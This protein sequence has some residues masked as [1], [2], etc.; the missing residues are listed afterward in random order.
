MHI[1]LVEDDP[2]LQLTTTA[3]V[4]RIFRHAEVE[5]VAS[6]AAAIG[7]L[8]SSAAPHLVLSDFDLADGSNGGEVLAWITEHRPK[9]V[10]RFV[11][12]SGN[13][14]VEE[15]HNRSVMKPYSAADLRAE[16]LRAI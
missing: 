2:N 8:T 3:L 5:V 7:A 16:L 10:E 4:R 6:A 13:P 1:L 9:L 15:I 14:I 11:F 12:L